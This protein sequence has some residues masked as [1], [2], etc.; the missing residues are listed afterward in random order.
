MQEGSAEPGS[1]LWALGGVSVLEGPAEGSRLP[2]THWLRAPSTSPA[3]RSPHRP[4][5]PGLLGGRWMA[6]AISGGVQASGLWESPI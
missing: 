1:R 5:P 2:L 3:C 4:N 6:P